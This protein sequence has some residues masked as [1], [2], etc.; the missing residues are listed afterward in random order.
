M[1][2]MVL[3]AG[4]GERM[5]PLTRILPKPAMPVLGRPLIEQVLRQ[6]ARQGVRDVV[7]NLHHLADRLA[8]VVGDGTEVGLDRLR[9]SREETIL[10]TGGGIGTWVLLVGKTGAGGGG[11]SG[12][13]SGPPQTPGRGPAF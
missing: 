4:R 13:I 6:L 1:I 8:S 3:A 7:M 11:A 2:A 12:R 10:G 5:L 9:L